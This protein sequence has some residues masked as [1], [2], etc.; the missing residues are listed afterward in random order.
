MTQAIRVP[1][2][3]V[4]DPTAPVV[5]FTSPTTN[6]GSYNTDQATVNI[7]G[8][9]SDP[10]TGIK[11]VEWSLDNTN[12]TTCTGTTAWSYS[13]VPLALGANTIYARGWN[14][15][16]MQTN[17]SITV[18]RYSPLP[19][20]V[21]ALNNSN[22]APTGW[23][24]CD[25]TNSTPN[26]RDYFI[27]CAGSSY[28]PGNTGGANNVNYAA[29]THPISNHTHTMNGTIGYGSGIAS[30][31]ISASLTVSDSYHTHSSSASLGAPTS[32]NTGSGGAASVEN[33][34][35]YYALWYIMK[36]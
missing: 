24:N 28:N 23:V 4:S 17:V 5:N 19:S 14:G 31:Y 25:G 10:E 13:G 6:G 32:A 15:A 30:S 11:L 36:T 26:V 29:H 21:I 12:W 2:A 8:T 27:P 22:T 35:P 7:A 18:T 20:G 16:H 34:P 33:R 9:A 3:R 1:L